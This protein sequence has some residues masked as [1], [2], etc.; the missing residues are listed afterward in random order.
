MT[1]KACMH[2]PFIFL[3]FFAVFL[4]LFFCF[5]SR[6]ELMAGLHVGRTLR[7]PYS[8]SCGVDALC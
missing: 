4:L 3:F 1:G 8:V 7:I 6:G 5:L 2:D